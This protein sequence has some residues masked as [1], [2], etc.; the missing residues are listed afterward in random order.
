M[1][2]HNNLADTWRSDTVVPLQLQQ[3]HWVFVVRYNAVE[4]WMTCNISISLHHLSE[5]LLSVLSL[6]AMRCYFITRASGVTDPP[7]N[8]KQCTTLA[9]PLHVLCCFCNVE[10]RKLPKWDREKKTSEWR[11]LGKPV[12]TL[13]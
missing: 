3:H 1:I 7:L 6:A 10:E 8:V 12:R 5:L 4:V 2:G 11:T 9:L 13:R